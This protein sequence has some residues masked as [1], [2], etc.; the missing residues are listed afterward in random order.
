[1]PGTIIQLKEDNMKQI[2]IRNLEDAVVHRLKK[3]AWMNGNSPE[4]MARQ[5]LI[6][7]IQG[8]TRHMQRDPRAAEP[9]A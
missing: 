7:A 2:V 9:A 1:M 4:E 8:T 5:L 3:S 6:E